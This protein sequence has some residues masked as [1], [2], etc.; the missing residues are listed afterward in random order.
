MSE[1]TGSKQQDK[2]T[3]AHV[4]P[5]RERVKQK[6]LVSVRGG[7]AVNDLTEERGKGDVLGGR[8][9]VQP[10]F[11]D[12]MSR[13]PI[14]PESRFTHDFSRI[15]THTTGITQRKEDSKAEEQ[16]QDNEF[17]EYAERL[18]DAMEGLGTE[19]EQIFTVLQQVGERPS[20][21]MSLK[22][23]YEKQYDTN[24]LDD[25]HSEMSGSELDFAL[26]LLGEKPS[27]KDVE[28]V[29]R[30]FSPED[31]KRAVTRL[32]DAMEGLG[33]N[34][35][36][37]FAV[38]VP[39][40]G[41]FDSIR[42]LKIAYEN[43]PETSLS[44]VEELREEMSGD[45]LEYAMNLLHAPL[46]PT[47]GMPERLATEAEQYAKGPKP[48]KTWKC[49][50]VTIVNYLRA[51][52]SSRLGVKSLDEAD[53]DR[54]NN[55]L[56]E[57]LAKKLLDVKP[58]TKN[59][60]NFRKKLNNKIII[61]IVKKL[62]LADSAGQFL[63]LWTI[64]LPD[65]PASW[66][67][68]GEEV[69][70][71]A[72]TNL[73]KHGLGKGV[74]HPTKKEKNIKNAIWG[75]ILQPGDVIQ[76]WEKTGM[77]IKSS[78]KGHSFIFIEYVYSPQLSPPT[79]YPSSW[80]LHGSSGRPI[81][82]EGNESTKRKIVKKTYTV[83]KGQSDEEV[84]KMCGFATMEKCEAMN[85]HNP[86]FKRGGGDT[87]FHEGAEIITKMS[88]SAAKSL[89]QMKDLQLVG[90][91]ITDQKGFVFIP[92]D[93]VHVSETVIPDEVKQK[94]A[95]WIGESALWVAARLE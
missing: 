49:T 87:W 24:L 33:T 70:H 46:K 80:E 9:A 44:L 12:M 11:A 43:D 71:G 56:G 23:A 40:A 39:F 7:T 8:T 68:E 81:N 25:L 2:T 4:K 48:I 73:E 34:E 19:E 14:S 29:P 63:A 50:H 16:N 51:Y 92:K 85:K 53:K 28:I 84:L 5:G 1:S 31:Y 27:S 30:T 75:E 83:K 61:P 58:E 54:L 22:R 47:R 69:R 90:M 76:T 13:V 64:H 86:K 6:Q 26:T 66:L 77:P 10:V 78:G 65:I 55:L 37:I 59:T 36:T 67:E 62:G 79:H 38:L 93:Q 82:T 88:E 89:K 20:A 74:K 3:K 91:R 32:K 17:K 45:E 94:R 95:K 18:K 15:K 21:V 52:I 72:V 60:K 42:Q 41:A 35:D 57:N